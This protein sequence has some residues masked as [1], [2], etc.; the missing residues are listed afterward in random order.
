MY[1]NL[2]KGKVK[3]I[4]N[5]EKQKRIA[6]SVT[7]LSSFLTPFMGSSINIA[8]PSIGKEF[9]MDALLL[10]WVA[11]S[12]LLT[13]AM[14]LVPFGKIADIYGRKKVYICGLLIYTLSSFISAISISAPMLIFSRIIQGFGAS[15]MFG[16]AVAILTSVFPFGERGRVLGIN[17]TAVYAGLSLGPFLGGFLTEHLGWRSIFFFNLPVGLIIIILVFFKLKGEWAEAK[18]EKFDAVGSII[19]CLLIVS[20]M[21][22]F[23][24]IPEIRGIFLILIGLI[25]IFLFIKWEIKVEN[26]LLNIKLFKDNPLF[27]F[28]N[29]AALINYSATFAVGFLLSLYL[30]YIKNLT[31]QKTGMILVSQPIV[32]AIFSPFA[33]RLSDRIEPRI[34]ASSGMTLSSGGLLLLSFLTERT[35]FEFIVLNLILL[36]FGLALFASPNTNAVMSSIEKRF[37]G[38]GASSLGTMRITGGML[39]MG[40][41]MLT[42]TIHLGKVQI[43]PQYYSPFLHSIKIAFIIFTLLCLCGTFASLRRGSI[44]KN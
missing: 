15:M 32:M 37:Y 8:L 25:G 12:F 23:S 17:V 40:I 7:T 22:G 11:T 33:G 35:T 39:S 9:S 19:Y 18:G 43:S 24:S 5:I 44:R 6:L 21:Y 31:P 10:S 36:G 41:A 28:S 14:F 34:V 1:E 38:V 3:N 20:I 29:L 2:N 26:P 4:N 13:S 30:Q 27:A 16:T 42:L